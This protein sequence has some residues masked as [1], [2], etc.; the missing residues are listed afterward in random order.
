MEARNPGWRSLLVGNQIDDVGHGSKGGGQLGGL[1]KRPEGDD[2][3]LP[4]TFGRRAVLGGRGGTYTQ[5]WV[6]AD[7]V[8]PSALPSS[9][10]LANVAT[11][12]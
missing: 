7:Q 11:I 8:S 10:G 3:R 4:G 6:A 2:Q 12:V 5:L 9:T 1:A